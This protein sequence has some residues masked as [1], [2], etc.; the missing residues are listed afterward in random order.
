VVPVR[1]ANYEPDSSGTN[2]GLLAFSGKL[3]KGHMLLYRLQTNRVGPS[4]PFYVR[5]P[6]DLRLCAENA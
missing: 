5:F 6:V 4:G 2:W 3:K 1:R